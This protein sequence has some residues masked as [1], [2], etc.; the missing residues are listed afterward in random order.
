MGECSFHSVASAHSPGPGAHAG[1]AGH[2]GWVVPRAGTHTSSSD[3]VAGLFLGGKEWDQSQNGLGL[4]V[5]EGVST[6]RRGL[7]V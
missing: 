3:M 2:A 4:Q 7:G 5:L 6:G 1:R